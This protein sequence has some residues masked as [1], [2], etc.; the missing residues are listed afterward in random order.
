MIWRSQ[1]GVTASLCLFWDRLTSLQNKKISRRWVQTE[2]LCCCWRRSV[3]RINF[4]TRRRTRSATWSAWWGVEE[5]MELLR[6]KS[7]QLFFSF[8]LL[9]GPRPGVRSDWKESHRRAESWKR[10]SE[11]NA[12]GGCW[13]LHAW[14]ITSSVSQL[15][16]SWLFSHVRWCQLKKWNELWMKLKMP[17]NTKG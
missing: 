2:K 3:T 10:L 9:S 7:G 13:Y 6:L 11:K 14:C 15:Q 5:L 4:W 17:S 12:R 16:M 8:L 1:R